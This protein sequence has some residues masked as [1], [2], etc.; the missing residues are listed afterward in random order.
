M[1][2]AHDGLKASCYVATGTRGL[3]GRVFNQLTFRSD[4]RLGYFQ[5]FSHS[6]GLIVLKQDLRLASQHRIFALKCAQPVTHVESIKM[7][8]RTRKL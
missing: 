4:S 8:I 7:G 1:T 6:Q 2:S 5:Q 3:P